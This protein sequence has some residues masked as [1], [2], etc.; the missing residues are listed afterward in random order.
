MFLG[1]LSAQDFAKGERL[2]L[3]GEYKK[4]DS[5]LL[6][7]GE[8]REKRA[9]IVISDEYV[10]FYGIAASMSPKKIKIIKT[11]FTSE[12][13]AEFNNPNRTRK[14]TKKEYFYEI[15][16]NVS[17]FVSKLELEYNSETDISRSS[18]ISSELYNSE[19][20]LITTF[21]SSI[22]EI[23]FSSDAKYFVATGTGIYPNDTL[24]FYNNLGQ[25]MGYQKTDRPIL[26]FSSNN[27]YLKVNNEEGQF[28]L[29]SNIGNLLLH[30]D[31]RKKFQQGYLSKCFVVDSLDYLL[32]STFVPVDKIS[33]IN[34]YGEILWEKPSNLVNRCLYSNKNLL[35]LYTID[36]K[37]KY[38]DESKKSIIVC[39]LDDGSV[40]DEIHNCN[41]IDF[42]DNKLIIM[43]GGVYYEYE[44]N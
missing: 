11:P 27:R 1:S 43:K 39:S 40:L 41:L 32:F 35:L 42:H 37:D 31:I 3:V 44:V 7:H 29:Y 9:S 15:I 23:I 26:E 21:G 2:K 34:M 28:W 19:G 38:L 16:D 17:L 6:H 13:I 14:V 4:F 8:L 18:R 12:D 10:Y 20:E 24:F 36:E 30:I 33:L 25:I 5:L 22:N